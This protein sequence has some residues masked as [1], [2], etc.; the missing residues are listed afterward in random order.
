MHN[1]IKVIIVYIF[2]TY[3]GNSNTTVC[4]GNQQ[5]CENTTCLRYASEE[6]TGMCS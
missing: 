3:L 1:N 6:T 5:Y 4:S 2:V